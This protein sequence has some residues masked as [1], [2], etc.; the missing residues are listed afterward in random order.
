SRLSARNVVIALL[1]STIL[2]MVGAR[3]LLGQRGVGAAATVPGAIAGE[4][5]VTPNGDAHYAI[6]IVAPPGILAG[7]PHLS[8]EYSSND[9]DG[10][11]GVGWRIGGLSA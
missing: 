7:G 1:L 6:P 9:G 8:L 4:F 10:R 11:L 2:A 3:A 5:A